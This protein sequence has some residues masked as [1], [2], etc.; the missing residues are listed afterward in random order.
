MPFP[1]GA[2][3]GRYEIRGALGAGGMG[4]VYRAYD[5][6]LDREVAI[7]VLGAALVA[8]PDALTRFEREAMSIAKLSHP[9]ILAIFEFGRE[10]STDLGQAGATFVVTELV[11]G[12]TLRARLEQGPLPPRKAVA[13]AL[14][15]AR[16]MGAAHAGGIVHRDLKPENIMVTRADQVKILDF[17]LAK[18][19]ELGTDEA[20]RGAG[21]VTGAGVVLGTFGYMAP[22]Q[23]RG[24]PIDHR[25]D[26][27]AF[28]ALLYE[29][30][31]GR[32]AFREDTAADT[33]TAILTKEPPDLDAA[34]LSISPALDRIVR[35]CLEKSPELRFQ[36]ANDLAFALETLS[37]DSSAASAR[38]DIELPATRQK[39][40]VRLPW[41]VAALALIGMAAAWIWRSPAGLPDPR[42]DTF[43]R[44]TEAAG[45]ET[46]PALSPDGS[47]V[48]Y[49][50]R[51]D[52]SWGIYAQRVGGRNATVLVDEPDRDEGGPAFSPDGARIAF[53]ESDEDGGIFV[54][55]ATGESVRRVTDI[56]FH[57]SWSPDGTQ[58]A[59]TTE[60]IWLPASRSGVATLYVVDA[61]GGAARQVV[62]GDAAQASWSPSGDRLVYW[63]NTNGQRD[64]FTVAAAGGARTAVTEDAA[65]DW[66]PVWSP[67][68]RF[69]YFS[70]ERGGAM[71]LWRI[72]VDP[73][74]GEPRGA[75]ETVTAGVQ[76]STGLPSFSKD[77]AR[78]AFRSRVGSV[79][80]V[81]IPFDPATMR[82]GTPFLLNTQNN[83]RIPSDVSRDGKQL[84]YYNLGER[85]EDAFVGLT[86]GSIR[87]V[88]DDAARDRAPVFTPDGRSLLFYSNREGKWDAWMVGIDGGG[89]RKV[90]T[91]QSNVN[92][93]QLSPDG[94]ALVFSAEALYQVPLDGTM[95]GTPTELPTNVKDGVR[96]WATD[97]SPDG[98]RLTGPLLS[99]SGSAIGIGIYDLG[100]QT[101]TPVGDDSTW[102]VQ[103]TADNR[104]VVYFTDGGFT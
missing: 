73:T 26:M 88:T 51:V 3:L 33:M 35:R 9:N 18:P 29:M 82:A 75:P 99:P 65:L 104:R 11:D 12:D 71:N 19:M 72:A 62:D 85:Q 45:E 77:G 80:P 25:A 60:E 57:P 47:T 66:S 14:Q 8:D 22:E 68:G 40:R 79:N 39:Q 46:S 1:V 63:S 102:A 91:T 15:I 98:R 27:F 10:P 28:G 31:S 53:H 5:P 94:D 100:T 24:Q 30:L 95:A 103:W 59:F 43:T 69:I 7:K 23:V 37:S 4:E 86:D 44:V 89:L 61:G 38:L 42:W 90:V 34:R 92:Y 74:T 36:S 84:A 55:G 67:D 17:G 54:A 87:R 48:A 78:L 93:P 52:G 50:A 97:W 49:A 76:A 83:I 81:A 20:T 13:Y 96:F 16:G 101:M 41:A 21:P 2:H 64:I 70:S 56:G 6:H 58:I 32:R